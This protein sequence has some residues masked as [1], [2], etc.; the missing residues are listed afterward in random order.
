MSNVS[1]ERGACGDAFLILRENQ[2]FCS[3]PG[4]S[5]P[6]PSSLLPGRTLLWLSQLFSPWCD[7]GGGF[8]E[9]TLS[10]L[11]MGVSLIYLRQGMWSNYAQEQVECLQKGSGERSPCFQERGARRSKFFFLR[12]LLCLDMKLA[13]WQPS[14]S[15][16]RVKLTQGLG[17]AKGAIETWNRDLTCPIQCPLAFGFPVM[18]NNKCPYC[19]SQFGL[20]FA[21]YA[22][23]S[24]QTYL[25]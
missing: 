25:K 3:R 19:W 11:V 9:Q 1:G 18:W 7:S 4:W 14:C 5:I 6:S 22:I 16:T 10:K 13:R 2:V 24:I 21:V 15:W 17:T 23:Q 20:V 12:I 8:Q